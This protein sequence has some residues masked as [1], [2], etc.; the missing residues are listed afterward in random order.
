MLLWQLRS[1]MRFPY[2]SFYRLLISPVPATFPVRCSLLD[3]PVLTVVG[4]VYKRRSCSFSSI[5]LLSSGRLHPFEVA[6]AFL[7]I[8]FSLKGKEDVPQIHEATDKIVIPISPRLSALLAFIYTGHCI[9]LGCHFWRSPVH[10]PASRA[11]PS[12]SIPLLN[13]PQSFQANV[14]IALN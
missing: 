5:H 7:K 12:L 4:N 6:Y 9:L 2:Q 11:A 1:S 8:C 10:I 3:V 13:I 14:R